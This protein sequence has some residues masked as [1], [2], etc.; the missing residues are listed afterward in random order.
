MGLINQKMER[1]EEKKERMKVNIQAHLIVGL[2]GT[3][4]EVLMIAGIFF[5][6]INGKPI[7]K[8]FGIVSGMFMIYVLYQTICVTTEEIMAEIRIF[9]NCTYI[10]IM[11]MMKD[12]GDHI[13]RID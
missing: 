12:K 10:S 9:W 8:L 6:T 11:T 2:I 1:L 13:P 7:E 4:L 5:L 3:I